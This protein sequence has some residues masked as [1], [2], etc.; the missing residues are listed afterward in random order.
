MN[1]AI[2][3][4]I[5]NIEFLISIIIFS[6]INY[7]LF[8]IYKDYCT[9]SKLLDIPNKRSSHTIATPKGAG[10]VFSITSI[11]F[12]IYIFKYYYILIL[13]PLLIIGFIDDLKGASR[14]SRLFVQIFTCFIIVYNSNLF[15]YFSLSNG[16]FENVLFFIF[17][18]TGSVGIIN[19]FNFSDGID[20]LVASSAGI[21][22]ILIGF[23]INPIFLVIGVSLF[24]FLIFNWFPAKLFMG[25]SGSTFIGAVVV[26]SALSKNNALDS[27]ASLLM[28]A[29]IIMDPFFCIIRRFLSKQNIFMAH[30]NHL[31]QR[32]HQSGWKHSYITLIY[33]VSTLLLSLTF[34]ILGLSF[35]TILLSIIFFVGLYLDIFH[36]VPFIRS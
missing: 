9:S 5:Y 15:Q 21:Y 24:I 4:N 27:L 29:P 19:F 34:I 10:I 18:V 14:I 23:Y 26:I 28:I 36:A 1:I 8:V 35:G 20:G 16:L 2:N 17:L 33:S 3:L 7:C 32:L 22:L 30:K 6:I 12:I 31:Y 13:I 25:D 11:I